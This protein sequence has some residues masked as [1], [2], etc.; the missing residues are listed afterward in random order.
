MLDRSLSLASPLCT[1]LG[2]CSISTSPSRCLGSA[3]K[4]RPVSLDDRSHQGD[5]SMDPFSRAVGRKEK[6]N[7]SVNQFTGVL[8][9]MA[10]SAANRIVTITLFEEPFPNV[11]WCEAILDKVWR[12]VERDHVQDHHRDIN[13]DSYVCLDR[14]SPELEADAERPV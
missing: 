5:L 1:L 11:Q 6:R 13:I 12:D 10:E 3:T 7:R 4:Q 2:S 8:R 9:E 14:R